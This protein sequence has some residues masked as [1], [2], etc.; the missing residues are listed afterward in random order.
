MTNILEDDY[1]HAVV[2]NLH[3][4]YKEY[5]VS[6]DITSIDINL[7]TLDTTIDHLGD[8]VYITLKDYSFCY[9]ITNHSSEAI[10][11]VKVMSNIG[12]G[13]NCAKAQYLEFHDTLIMPGEQLDVCGEVNTGYSAFNNFC[14]AV[15]SINGQVDANLD[16]NIS[17]RLLTSSQ[18]LPA[19]NKVNVFPNPTT[20][21]ITFNTENTISKASIY[22]ISG[23]QVYSI[24][25]VNNNSIAVD[26]L[27]SGTYVI[28]GEGKNGDFVKARFVKM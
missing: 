26:Y 21:T 24:S 23:Q 10:S 22:P 3:K 4:E 14:L 17:C 11:N 15:Y 19:I 12:G 5:D 7:D 9:S 8:T 2:S 1:T 6:V 20:E 27:S 13:V 16:N 25:K 28:I 18:E